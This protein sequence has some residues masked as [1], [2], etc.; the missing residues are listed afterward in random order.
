MPPFRNDRLPRYVAGSPGAQTSGAT[1]GSHVLNK[2][3]VG[4]SIR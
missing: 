1:R 3:P 2:N 4:S